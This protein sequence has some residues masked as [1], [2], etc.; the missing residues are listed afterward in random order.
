MSVLWSCSERG[1]VG[2]GVP[3]ISPPASPAVSS[4]CVR[5]CSGVD[6]CEEGGV[7]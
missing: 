2:L 1:G 7:G 6:V 3:H 4:T 5:V